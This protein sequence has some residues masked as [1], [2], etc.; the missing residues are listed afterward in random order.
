M[1]EPSDSDDPYELT[2]F[3]EAQNPVYERVLAE[4]R[5][6]RK[7]SHWMWFVFPQISGLGHSAMARRYAIGSLA[8][9]AA[10][11]EHPIL[12]P[13]LRECTSLVNATQGRSA[14]EIFGSPDDLKFRSSMTLFARATT[15]EDV[16]TEAL[17]RFFGGE[18]DP[19][20][21]STLR[22]PQSA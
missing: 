10:Y 22:S 18:L 9:A 2:R 14:H 12:G 6:G 15:D 5:S 21:I 8:E 7:T 4:L 11:L 13:R 16:F 20:T 17:R 3:V 19:V 1:P